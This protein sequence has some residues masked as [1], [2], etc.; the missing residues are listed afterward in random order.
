MRKR[1][2]SRSI[3]RFVV[4]QLSRGQSSESARVVSVSRVGKC[5]FLAIGDLVRAGIGF[6]PMVDRVFVPRRSLASF[7]YHSLGS[8]ASDT[9]IALTHTNKISSSCDPYTMMMRPVV[10][11]QRANEAKISSSQEKG[12]KPSSFYLK[13]ERLLQMYV[14]GF[15]SLKV[16]Y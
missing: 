1:W 14:Y 2:N 7:P 8:R 12:A 10:D 5:V 4:V 9:R 15:T 13:A 6:R 11:G 16:L 3:L